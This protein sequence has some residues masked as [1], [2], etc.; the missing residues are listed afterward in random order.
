MNKVPNIAGFH[1][2]QFKNASI[3][4]Y[5]DP[6]DPNG[7]N[8]NGNGT[9]GNSGSNTGTPTGGQGAQALP[10]FFMMKN[11]Q[12]QD[13]GGV[14]DT[15]INMNELAKNGAYDV[16]LFRDKI[17]TKMLTN[18]HEIKHPNVLLIGEAGTGKT[19]L[20]E[21]LARRIVLENASLPEYY[22]NKVIYELPINNLVAGGSLVGEVEQRVKDAIDF[23]TNPENNAILYID[24]IHQLYSKNSSTQDTIAQQLKPALARGDLHVIASTTT[25]EGRRLSSDPA[26]QRRFSKIT[27]PELTKEETLGIL[28]LVRPKYEKHNNIIIPVDLLPNIVSLADEYLTTARPDSAL[29]L[30]DQA[31]SD[32]Y[33]RTAQI[34]K[35][36]GSAVGPLSLQLVNLE[37]TI[38]QITS[39]SPKKFPTIDELEASIKQ[40]V[41]GQDEA[42]RTA[43]EALL[44]RQLNIFP[45]KRPLSILLAGPTGTGKSELAKQIAKNIFGSEDDLIY[46]NMTEYDTRWTMSKITGSPDGYV[47]SDS[48]GKL[49]FD[50]LETNPSQVI[51]LDEFEKADTSIQNLFM[52]ALDEGSFETQRHNKIDFSKAII[53]ATSNAG[54]IVDNHVGFGLQSAKS[55]K[56]DELKSLASDFKIELLNRFQHVIRVNPIDIDTYKTIVQTKYLELIDS[57]K[58]NHPEWEFTPTTFV[59]NNGNNLD[60]EFINKIVDNSYSKELNARPAKR[61]VQKFIE[62]EIM[63][64][65]TANKFN[66]Q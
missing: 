29:T 16:A 18:L 51:L 26:I 2:K 52:Q 10:P 31:S 39:H 59:D 6:K 61:E 27:V 38:A 50:D 30:I 7:N 40:V 49:P 43:S 8:G 21:E 62:D 14:P 46:L 25:Q 55:K 56:D 3:H 47:G 34:S 9:N 20:V 23:A 36:L 24:E 1:Q 4:N 5:G 22:Q 28:E 58:E 17:I 37:S 12:N 41:K 64:T 66:F 32:L 45:E 35:N 42:V 53:I 11:L 48:N 65:P 57:T 15:L 63:K 60:F 54:Q 44:R 33:I 13:D 19:Q